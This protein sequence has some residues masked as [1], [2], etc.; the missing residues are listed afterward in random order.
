MNKYLVLVVDD[1]PD[2]LLL[3]TN[4]L[5]KE[6]VKIH[7]VQSGLDALELMSL[8]EYDAIISDMVMPNMNGLELAKNTNSK[9]PF[10]LISG[11]ETIDPSK[12]NLDGFVRK[13]DLKRQLV[14]ATYLAI[15][16]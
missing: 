1:D 5:A 9:T 14:N 4:V 12:L 8:Y 16:K 7:M 15:E 11:T 3:I 2:M 6:P 13:K 10:V